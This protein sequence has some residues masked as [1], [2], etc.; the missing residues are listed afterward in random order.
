MSGASNYTRRRSALNLSGPRLLVVIVILVVLALLVGR[1]FKHHDNKYE[2]LARNV[3]VALQNDDVDAVKKYQ[4]AETATTITRGVVGRLSDRL[5]PLGKLKT[6]KE[7]TPSDA[8]DQIHDFDVAFE[9]G[10][11][12]ETMKVDPDNKIVHFRIPPNSP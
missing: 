8:P 2:Q 9:K 4:N 5:A 12:H 1:L 10:T 11:I 7:T 3:T 6:V